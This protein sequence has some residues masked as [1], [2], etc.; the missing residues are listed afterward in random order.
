MDGI[1]SGDEVRIV[2]QRQRIALN[3]VEQRIV[4][5]WLEIHPGH[6]KPGPLI[7]DRAAAGAAEQVQ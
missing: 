2:E 1:E 7:T 4:V 6:F 3:E 5:H